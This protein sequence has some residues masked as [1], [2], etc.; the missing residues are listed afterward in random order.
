MVINYFLYFFFEK[1][2]PRILFR[3]K[4]ASTVSL[5]NRG[6]RGGGILPF[7]PESVESNDPGGTPPSSRSIHLDGIYNRWLVV[8]GTFFLFP[9]IGNSNP[10]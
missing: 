7:P 10:N 1:N 2:G 4:K 9:Y 8:T 3:Q 5:R 6:Y